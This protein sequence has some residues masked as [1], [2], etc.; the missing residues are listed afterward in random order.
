MCVVVFFG[1]GAENASAANPYVV[2]VVS[3][4][5]LRTLSSAS[6]PSGCSCDGGSPGSPVGNE[7]AKSKDCCTRVGDD[8]APPKTMSLPGV[9]PPS[10]LAALLLLLLLLL[11]GLAG[12]AG[13][14]ALLALLALLIP[15]APA[16][17]A[18]A[19][20]SSSSSSPPPPGDWR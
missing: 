11:L 5:W 19:S 9:L 7:P 17:A 4:V 8:P 3:C 10:L 2:V 1:G 16:A 18:A 12:L 14:A 13:L 20:S 6:S 15:P